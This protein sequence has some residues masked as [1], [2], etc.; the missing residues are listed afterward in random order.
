M[1]EGQSVTWYA[2]GMTALA[3]TE[4]ESPLKKFGGILLTTII[5]ITII[6][7]GLYFF[8]LTHP[9]SNLGDHPQTERITKALNDPKTASFY[10]DLI[11][12]ETTTDDN[13]S[14]ARSAPQFN[15]GRYT[16]ATTLPFLPAQTKI[17]TFKNSFPEDQTLTLA[18]KLLSKD[19]K[20]VTTKD[21]IRTYSSTFGYLVF[22]TT[23]GTFELNSIGATAPFEQLKTIND[24]RPA[25]TTYLQDKLNIIDETTT[26]SA[27]YQRSTSPDITYYE[28]HR[29][30]EK[31]G[32]HIINPVGVAN[33]PEDI[34]LKKVSI[35][36]FTVDS[37]NDPTIILAS[38][39]PGKARRNDFNTLT[40]G[41]N[42]S[43]SIVSLESNLRP[44]ESSDYVSGLSLSILS[45][46]QA[47]EELQKQGAYFSITVPAGQGTIDY[48][49]VYLNNQLKTQEAVITDMALTYI[50]K[51]PNVAQR[52]LQPAYIV[53]G[54]AETDTG[55][56]VKFVQTVPAISSLENTTSGVVWS[57]AQRLI[58]PAFAI[59]DETTIPCPGGSGICTFEKFKTTPTPVP[60]QFTPTQPTPTRPQQVA[61]TKPILTTDRCV[62]YNTAGD[63]VEEGRAIFVTGIGTVYYFGN[64]PTGP[65]VVPNSYSDLYS[66]A[67]EGDPALMSYAFEEKIQNE[68]ITI[69]ARIMRDNPSRIRY[70]NNGLDIKFL[71]Q[72]NTDFQNLPN[73]DYGNGTSERAIYW[74]YVTNALYENRFNLDQLAS[75]PTPLKD[76][77]LSNEIIWLSRRNAHQI[78]IQSRIY[79]NFTLDPR[80]RF[81]TTISPLIF[82]Y[83]QTS[84]NM[85]LTFNHSNI[86]YIDPVLSKKLVFTAQ[87][88][89]S[90]TFNNGVTRDKIHYEYA[91]ISF[92]RPTSGWIVATENI[93]KTVTSIAQLLELT[94]QESTSLLK[95]TVRAQAILPTNQPI[96]VGIIDEATLN[97]K[98]PFTL[99]P[100]PNE[101]RRIHLYFEPVGAA[102]T[103]TK[104]H[105]SA[106]KRAG[107]TVIELGTYVEQ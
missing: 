19:A 16:V 73:V 42:S 70:G 10:R 54:Y 59:G 23:S 35:N 28:F 13:E 97:K 50:E 17:Y 96:F 102:T 77:G 65:L 8:R 78:G 46:D 71:Y 76:A 58:K 49:K 89:G 88:N 52:Y 32:L 94:T 11:P 104:P 4:E 106:I 33:L 60:R 74:E 36:S 38:D 107:F 15:V 83:T 26:L 68:L 61:P 6:A 5:V 53:R 31:I 30:P 105:I 99:S 2:E 47:L 14:G 20:L 93:E 95:E 64:L 100:Q 62:L 92:E 87:P 63:L 34:P 1:L 79:N 84:T 57:V 9:T 3:Y 80:C 101:L 48:D 43:G 85:T 98:L 12:A 75:Q 55:V 27:Y 21:G 56:R 86:T 45:P 18:Q 29:D 66:S 69:G 41:I 103:T 82:F 44:V 91:H 67:Q 24:I 81:L 72:T 39:S 51:P 37:A 25:L 90:L 22:N 7:G 40:V